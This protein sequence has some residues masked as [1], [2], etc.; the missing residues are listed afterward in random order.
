MRPLPTWT[1]G[2]FALAAGYCMAI[3]ETAWL[4]Q[5]RPFL[6]GT[7]AAAS[8]AI[9]AVMAGLGIGAL[10]FGQASRSEHSSVRLYARLE[11]SLA[12][13]AGLS[14][15]LLQ[16]LG[17]LFL[18][19]G[20][21]V[22]S[23]DEIVARQIGALIVITVP[24]VMMGGILPALTRA[25]A[26][27]ADLRRW[28]ATVV[29]GLNTIGGAAGVAA[30]TFVLFEMLGTR[31]SIWHAAAIDGLMG[32]IALMISRRYSESSRSDI[33][34]EAPPAPAPD[35][36]VAPMTEAETIQ[37][38]QGTPVEMS[39]RLILLLAA[40]TGCA[41]M[42]LELVWFR[43]LS[44]LL[45]GSVYAMGGILLAAFI[46]LGGGALMTPVLQRIRWIS[47]ADQLAFILMAQACV[48]LIAYCQGDRLAIATQLL[49]ID[50]DR[51]ARGWSWVLPTLAIVFPCAFI[52]GVQ[53]PSFISLIGRDHRTVGRDCGWVMAVNGAGSVVGCL[54]TGAGLLALLTAPVTWQGLAV[55]YI[56][57]ALVLAFRPG[58]K[59]RMPWPPSAIV[60]ISAVVITLLFTSRGPTS[61][62]RHAIVGWEW[63]GLKESR[64][65]GLAWANLWRRSLRWEREGRDASVA[66][67]TTIREGYG[68]NT[69]GG[70]EG[71]ARGDLALNVFS[72]LL[73]PLLRPQTKSALVVG[74][75]TGATAGWLATVPTLQRVDVIEIEPAVLPA[76]RFFDPVNMHP[77]SNPKVHV[78]VGDARAVLQTR[79]ATYDIIV[80]IPSNLYRAGV[81][82]LFTEE[83]Y[84]TVRSRLAPGGLFL[85]WA[86]A[87]DID[88]DSLAIVHATLLAAFPHVE[89]WQPQ[90]GHLLLVASD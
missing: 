61:V 3:Y 74:L 53:I 22:S 30:G 76:A 78:I 83:Y 6:G 35:S 48:I 59:R 70:G 44:S 77:L 33:A 57:L 46:G 1:A 65:P 29:Y 72:G 67:V 28:R 80:S 88:A 43:M 42:V 24:A 14:P 69:N 64:N 8:A 37:A 27:A 11:V 19:T 58:K 5:L 41:F 86:Q 4:R 34:S 89:S 51:W 7:T 52:A 21:T 2:L 12:V 47:R 82:A 62:W 32:A 54:A 39:R 40:S 16:Y 15:L 13:L 71:A 31:A 55:L 63:Q 25:S 26:R 87:Y 36:E 90:S 9:A 56:L 38:L 85:Q 79:P 50:P 20:A 73:G 68:L 10:L 18:R 81:A 17:D 60:A 84:R 66:V 45:G 23:N 49:R 75:G